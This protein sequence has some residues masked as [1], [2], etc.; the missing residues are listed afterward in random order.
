MTL[1]DARKK[2]LGI[3]KN[4]ATRPQ[5]AAEKFRAFVKE[6]PS[7]L[8]SAYYAWRTVFKGDFSGAPHERWVVVGTDKYGEPYL[9]EG[10]PRQPMSKDEAE[11][12]AGRVN[13]R[14]GDVK[15][16][17]EVFNSPG[18]RWDRADD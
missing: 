9:S 12:E 11:Q 4:H 1:A 10:K 2:L 8:L 18:A 17:R 13:G 15:A 5:V 3:A 16:V 6:H 14:G 7:H